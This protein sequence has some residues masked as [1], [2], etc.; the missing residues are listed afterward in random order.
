MEPECLLSLPHVSAMELATNPI[1]SSPHSCISK[2]VSFEIHFNVT[3]FCISYIPH[4][5]VIALIFD[6]KI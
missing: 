5:F 4:E 2:D 3:L 6:S 1:G